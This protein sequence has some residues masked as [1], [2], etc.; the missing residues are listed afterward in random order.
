MTQQVKPTSI[1]HPRGDNYNKERLDMKNL[2][3]VMN[4]CTAQ[5][6]IPI[7]KTKD[8][9]GENEPAVREVKK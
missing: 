7:Y 6:R 8:K 2:S 5:D 4:K 9:K 1:S 3:P